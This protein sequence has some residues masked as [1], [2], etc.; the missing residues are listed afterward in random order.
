MASVPG[1]GSLGSGC[2]T[3]PRFRPISSDMSCSTSRITR[4]GS[5]QR[6]RR[7]VASTSSRCSWS[8][9]VSM[10]GLR[11]RLY[12][13]G[14]GWHEPGGSKGGARGICVSRAC[15]GLRAAAAWVWPGFAYGSSRYAGPHPHRRR[16]PAVAY[17]GWGAARRATGWPPQRIRIPISEGGHPV[18]RRVLFSQIKVSQRLLNRRRQFTPRRLHPAAVVRHH[19]ALAVHQVLVEVP[20]RRLAGGLGQAPGTAHAPAR[21]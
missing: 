5:R 20:A 7:C 4:S 2:T 13:G 14:F 17:P 9:R 11:A 21:P 12:C 3:R 6:V 16:T 19:L 8:A 1:A 10:A 18:A 15:F